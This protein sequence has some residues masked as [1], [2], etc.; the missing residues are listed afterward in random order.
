MAAT[1]STSSPV[2]CSNFLS[3]YSAVHD[4]IIPLGD[5]CCMQFERQPNRDPW[6]AVPAIQ[7]LS[8]KL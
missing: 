5:V 7:P 8:H 1:L 4:Q 2:P 6:I 3:V